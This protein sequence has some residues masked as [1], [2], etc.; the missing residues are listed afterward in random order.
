M[1]SILDKIKISLDQRK[2]TF[3]Q[4]NTG[5][6]FALELKVNPLPGFLILVLV[7]GLLLYFLQF[8]FYISMFL[9]WFVNI[10]EI[11]KVLKLP[12]LENKDIYRYPALAVYFYFSLSVILDLSSF[13]QKSWGNRWVFTD[14][15]L[16]LIQKK[17][18]YF[19][20]T[21]I[22]KTSFQKNWDWQRGFLFDLF[23]LNSI[24][25]SYKGVQYL[26]P[27]FFRKP[28]DEILKKQFHLK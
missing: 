16:F 27:Y 10:L 2:K 9:E 26:S 13:L 15:G 5:T 7:L 28:N 21:K 22:P 20:I 19:K 11:P 18:L 25:L 23:G 17:I 1:R 24:Q 4:K 12:F 8:I 14:E 3:Y 6:Q